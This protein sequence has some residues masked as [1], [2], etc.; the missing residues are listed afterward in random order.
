ML[1]IDSTDVV[2]IATS[3]ITLTYLLQKKMDTKDWRR[4]WIIVVNYLQLISV[5]ML[6]SFLIVISL[7]GVLHLSGLYRIKWIMSM[8]TTIL[9]PILLCI[10]GYLIFNLWVY[11]SYFG[12][13][14][15]SGDINRKPDQWKKTYIIIISILTIISV[16]TNIFT[17][18]NKYFSIR[19][20]QMKP[21]KSKKKSTPRRSTKKSK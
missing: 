11:I 2:S 20:E 12:L 19:M 5:S 18:Y 16:A 4:I 6:T 1:Q 8:P 15:K 14:L 7:L 13:S 10:L 21:T 3:V 9:F 17:S